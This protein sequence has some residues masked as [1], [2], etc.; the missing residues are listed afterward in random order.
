M[1][2][3]FQMVRTFTGK[4]ALALILSL[5]V[6]SGSSA[7]AASSSA[8]Y[9]IQLSSDQSTYT[10]GQPIVLTVVLQNVG[11]TSGIL[12]TQYSPHRDVRLTVTSQGKSLAANLPF[13]GERGSGRGVALRPGE[14]F[15]ESE[16]ISKW[17]YALAP[18]DYSITG[19]FYYDVAGVTLT[20]N[21]LHITVTP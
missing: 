10:A 11:N 5:A 1:K 21:S 16:P 6:F 3:V 17:R 7:V 18:G 20:T 4:N 2:G 8:R 12:L 19:Q 9:T 15:S 13:V 14:K